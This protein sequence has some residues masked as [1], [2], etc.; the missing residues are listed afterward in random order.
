MFSFAKRK[1]TLPLGH[2]RSS[3]NIIDRKHDRIDYETPITYKNY[4]TKE[5]I[6]GVLHNYSQG[7]LYIEAEHCPAVGIGA[8]IHMDNYS[9]GASGPDNVKNYHVQVRWVKKISVTGKRNLYGIGVSHCKDIDEL[10]RLFG[11]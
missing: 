2:P 4:E 7:G 6:Q 11:H 5:I 8:L 10:F 1:N 3:P 9:P